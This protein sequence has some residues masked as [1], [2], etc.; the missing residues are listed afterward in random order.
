MTKCSTGV[1]RYSSACASTFLAYFV[2]N[3]SLAPLEGLDTFVKKLLII[4]G[5]AVSGLSLLFPDVYV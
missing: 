5:M 1:H 3:N 4:N 2:E